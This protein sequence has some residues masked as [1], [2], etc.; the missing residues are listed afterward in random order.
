MTFGLRMCALAFWGAH[1]NPACSAIKLEGASSS[2]S[3]A[4]F[5]PGR[6]QF[7]Q[8]GLREKVTSWRAGRKHGD[9]S[10]GRWPARKGSRS[11]RPSPR[12]RS[13]WRLS[14]MA[15][16]STATNG[17]S[18]FFDTPELELFEAGIIARARRIVGCDA[19][20]HDQVPAGRCRMPCP[21]LWRKKS[22]FKIE[23]DASQKGVVK[24]ASLTMPVRK[25]LIKR[26]AAGKDPIA[27][28]FTEEQLS[29]SAQHGEQ[30]DRLRQGRGDGPDSDLALE[31]RRPR[32]CPG[33]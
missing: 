3:A 20:Q 16:S 8:G 27:S 1:F 11:R 12:N 6:A 9:R 5:K 23:A 10:H 19:R 28:L 13:I 4:G 33:R 31:V 15:S 7:V 2:H 21:V 30:E 17:L 14:S 29:V 18:T 25:G 26:V 32:R 22:G 24:S